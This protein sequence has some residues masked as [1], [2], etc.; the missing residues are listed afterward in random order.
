MEKQLRYMTNHD[1]LTG[2]YNRTFFEEEL[3]RLD[4]GRE[5][6]I[7]IIMAD[8][9]DLKETNDNLGHETGDELLKRF[10]QVLGA[11]FR[12]EDVA[13]RIGG[14]EFAVLLPNTG[15]KAAGDAICRVKRMLEE[16]NTALVGNPLRLSFGV[17]SAET[18]A[19]LTDLVRDADKKMYAEKQVHMDLKK[20]SSPRKTGPG[21][22][23]KDSDLDSC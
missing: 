7:S 22:A 12:K 16:H 20:K 19:S 15:K 21:E 1:T 17:S 23:T 8:I 9:D 5:F 4:R 10:A 6:P 18:H 14:D 13:A 3:R 11:S 2:L